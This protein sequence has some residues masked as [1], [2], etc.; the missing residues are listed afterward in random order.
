MLESLYFWKKKSGETLLL[1]VVAILLTIIF[2]LCGA[3]TGYWYYFI[4]KPADE[5]QAQQ[6]QAAQQLRKDIDTVHD[7]YAKSLEGADIDSALRLLAELHRS[8]IPLRLIHL[9]IKSVSYSCSMKSCNMRFELEPGAII[10]QP[11]LIFLNK[12]YQAAFPVAKGKDKDST[13]SLEF[14][15]MKFST[16]SNNHAK[17]YKSNKSL[18]LPVCNDVISYIKTYNSFL[19]SGKERFKNGRIV[20]KMLPKS[21]VSELE[22]KLKG[23]VKSYE[24]LSSEW[25]IEFVEAKESFSNAEISAQLALYKQAYRDA[26]LIR[27]I[28]TV[29]QGIKISGG[30]ICKA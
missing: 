9:P 13:L 19:S 20:F 24:M 21:P 6:L 2:L 10:T 28:E 12:T 5:V 3:G 30:L 25:S 11:S 4:K 14:N 16:L 7:W 22:K 27:K 23:Q 15:N 18:A 8:Y 1:R 17:A 26:F 29:K